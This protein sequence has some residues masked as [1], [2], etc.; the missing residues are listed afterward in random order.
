MAS[1]FPGMDLYLEKRGIWR[2]FHVQ[3]I[4]TLARLINDGANRRYRAGI[5]I[6]IV[7]REPAAEERIALRADVAV[8]QTD[9]R[10][11]THPATSSAVADRPLTA[12][13]PADVYEEKRYWIEVR[14]HDRSGDEPASR[15]VTHVEVLSPSNKRQDRS[16][17]VRKRFALCRSEDVN[18]V[19]IDL[20][21]GGNRMSIDE[22]PPCDGYAM[23]H[24]PADD[25][26]VSVWPIALRHA[27]PKI[28]IP[29]L[30]EDGD[31]TVDLQAA[32]DRAYEE[33][34][35][36]RISELYAASP[37]PPLSPEDAAWAEALL[38]SASSAK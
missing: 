10:G 24:R 2:E 30:P 15:L 13:L 14:V 37:E 4:H 28:P 8:T 17:Y 1:P 32:A 7:L 21:R 9:N 26:R 34:S 11:P 23:V 33:G 16:E 27:L 20:L 3:Y 6:D 5:E 19:E 36:D 35:F 25:L 29:L 22:L 38:A 12:L 31:V 18:F